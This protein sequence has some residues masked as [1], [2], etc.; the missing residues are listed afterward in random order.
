MKRLGDGAEASAAMLPWS[1]LWWWVGATLG[2]AVVA[3]R[4]QT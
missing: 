4:T 2:C 3:S 1:D